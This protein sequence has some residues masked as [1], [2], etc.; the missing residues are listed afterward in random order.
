MRLEQFEYVVVTAECQSMSAA[1][2]QL[3][4]T[5]QCIS[6]AIKQLEDEL[7]APLFIRSK[8]GV[9]LTADGQAVYEQGK[10]IMQAVHTLRGSYMA[11]NPPPKTIAGTLRVLSSAALSSIALKTVNALSQAHPQL[12]PSVFVK[13]VSELN[14]NLFPYSEELDSYDIILTSMGAK[15]LPNC[16]FLAPHYTIYFLR[17]D[18][19]A[20]QMDHTAP[21]AQLDKIPLK[22][23]TT[24]PLVS[25][26][27][28]PNIPSQLFTLTEDFGVHLTPTF[29]SNS[30]QGCANY[31]KNNRAYGLVTLSISEE[32]FDIPEELLAI[33]IKERIYLTHLLFIKKHSQKSPSIKAFRQMI[34]RHFPTYRKL[35]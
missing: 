8:Y 34:L 3:H 31:V 29:T 32:N 18:R 5:S 23:L 17:Q 1:A 24:L 30:P 13:E 6:K 4:V 35:Y 10:T 19:L 14:R 16:Q 7:G 9:T 25:Y 26:V 11:D 27:T 28:A 20:L 2:D 15:N 22:M 33:P 21:L 12:N